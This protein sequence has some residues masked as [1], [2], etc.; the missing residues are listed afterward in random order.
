MSPSRSSFAFAALAVAA[1]ARPALAEPPKDGA[2]AQPP[3]P[4]APAPTA[5]LAPPEQVAAALAKFKEDY[6]AKGLK[7]DD[8]LAQKDFAVAQISKLQHPAVIDAIAAV[9][10]E[11]DTTLRMLGVI[12]LSDQTL[13]PGAAG[14]HASAAFKRAGDDDALRMTCLQTIGRLRFLGA[15]PELRDGLKSL[16]FAV[17]KSALAATARTGDLR[18]LHDVLAVVGVDIPN[19]GTAS[20]G[21]GAEDPKSSGGKEVV[22]EGYSWEGAEASVDTGTAGDS[23]QK[24]AEAQAKAEAAANEAAAR[25]SAGAS[26]SGGDGGGATMGRGGSSRNP[27][28]LLPQ[29]LGVLQALTGRTFANAGEFKRWYA[30]N[31]DALVA[32]MRE[33]DAKEKAQKT[34]AAAAVKEAAAAAKAA[35]AAR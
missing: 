6:K 19:D 12:Y 29:V 27:K 10:R 14:P 31:R 28:E 4:A 26:G 2:P 22:S 13:L 23:D 15:R 17:R 7:G 34:D 30:V 1:L 21:G 8:K 32:K 18:L 5:T 35:A 25:E 16:S 3:A 11:S 9:S 20:S 33:L 24:A